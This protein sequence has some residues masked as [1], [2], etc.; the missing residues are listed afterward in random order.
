MRDR[1]HLRR[2]E[3][4]TVPGTP[5]FYLTVCVLDRAPV[6][7]EA[8]AAAVL[9]EAWRHAR[10]QHGWRVGR[11]CVM[12]DHVHFFASPAHD[13]ARRLSSFGGLWKRS[14]KDRLRRVVLPEFDWQDEFFDHLLRSAASYSEKLDYVYQNP[15]RA[16]LVTDPADW[17]YQGV[18]EEITM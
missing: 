3:R 7:P 4:V 2:L 17:P 10:R 9:V 16:G 14:T 11:Y 15:V 6:L 12:P 8:R 13:A 5:V 1:K 18:I